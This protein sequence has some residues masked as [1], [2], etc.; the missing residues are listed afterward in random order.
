VCLGRLRSEPA[1]VN[2]IFLDE[3]ARKI[4]SEKLQI[5]NDKSAFHNIIYQQQT[6][7]EVALGDQS[8]ITDRGT[9]DIFAFHPEAVSE[10][11]T[12]IQREF[13]RYT[14]VVQLG[15]SA[16][17]GPNHYIGDDIRQETIEE[18][19]Q[20]ERALKSV[21]SAHPAYHFIAASS[22]LDKKYAELR[23]LIFMLAGITDRINVSTDET[24]N[25]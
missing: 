22:D 3:L 12:S 17:L 5:R 11:G 21:W 4:L 15:S 7:R 13:E 16:S 1:M 18:T 9:A 19:L 25:Q 23:H 14:A 24:S 2:F 6:A 10:I 8:F 20:I